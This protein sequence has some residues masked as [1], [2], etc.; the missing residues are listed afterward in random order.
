MHFKR[1]NYSKP[2][3]ETQSLW[4]TFDFLFFGMGAI[5]IIAFLLFLILFLVSTSSLSVNSLTQ[6]SLVYGLK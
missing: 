6:Q 4:L 5:F 3:E 2:L 1:P